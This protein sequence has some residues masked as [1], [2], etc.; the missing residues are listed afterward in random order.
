MLN[1]TCAHSLRRLSVLLLS[2]SYLV[3][4][5]RVH[6]TLCVDMRSRSAEISGLQ[7]W[8]LEVESLGRGVGAFGVHSCA[9]DLDFMVVFCGGVLKCSDWRPHGSGFLG[10]ASSAWKSKIPALYC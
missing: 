9:A 2:R 7:L 3:F 4:A 5:A 10:W 6:C 1:E 8:S